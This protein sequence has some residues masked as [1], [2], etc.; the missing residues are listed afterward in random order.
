M[1]GV[2]ASDLVSL[3]QHK[4]KDAWRFTGSPSTP[5]KQATECIQLHASMEEEGQE[6]G[7]GGDA[8]MGIV[9]M[10]VP[11]WLEVQPAC[12]HRQMLRRLFSTPQG[13]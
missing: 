1:A 12:A 5:R 7:V 8:C 2:S 10:M 6:G 13:R 4:V 9:R 11:D 3:S